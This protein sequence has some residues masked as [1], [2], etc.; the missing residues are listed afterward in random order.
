M[1]INTQKAPT[2]DVKVRQAIN[3]AIDKQG[4]INT[5]FKGTGEAAISYLAQALLPTPDLKSRYP[6]DLDKAKQMLEDAGWTAGSGDIR[7]RMANI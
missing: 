2:D 4:M 1:L 3:Y 5:L 7:R 6:F